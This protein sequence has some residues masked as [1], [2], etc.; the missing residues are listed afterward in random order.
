MHKKALEIY[1]IEINELQIALDRL[2]DVT[3]LVISMDEMRKKLKIFP[4][5]HARAGGHPQ[6][7]AVNGFPLSLE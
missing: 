5:R 7:P 1:T 6:T 2:H 4:L 3:D